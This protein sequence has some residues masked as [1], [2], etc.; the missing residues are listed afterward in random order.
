MTEDEK[1]E[2]SIKFSLRWEGGRNFTIING[3][4]LIKGAARADLGGA[5]AYGVTWSTL[6]S[7]YKQGITGHDDICKLTLDEAKKIYRA[8]YW[9]KY[10]WGEVEYPAC[11]C[12][13]DCA[14]NHGGFAKILQRAVNECGGNVVVD[15]KM[16]PKT[17]TGI[18]GIE[19]GLL[20][21]KIC[22]EREKYFRDI[23]RKRPGQGV[24]LKGWL[25]R[26]NAM[27]DAI[28]N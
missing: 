17:L 12:C 11:L 20:G 24:F 3:K 26:V 2:R 10:G 21:E 7:A 23:V 1:F 4:P 22:D 27:R 18:K 5:T 16:G 15:G 8:N 14:I 19:P 9:D 6:K 13:L 28:R 25:R